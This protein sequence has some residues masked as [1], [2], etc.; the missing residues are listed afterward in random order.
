MYLESEAILR[1]MLA[2]KALGIP[3]L[4]VQDS[5][6]VQCRREGRWREKL[7]PRCIRPLLIDAYEHEPTC[8]QSSGPTELLGLRPASLRLS[9]WR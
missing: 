3:S 5:I 1:T 2:L 9:L 8:T 6:I 7:Y 4:S